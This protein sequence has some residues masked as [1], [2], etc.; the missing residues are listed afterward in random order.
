MRES[1]NII[2]TWEGRTQ[3]GTRKICAEEIKQNLDAKTRNVTGISIPTD[4]R[5][6]V[7]LSG[8]ETGDEICIRERAGNVEAALHAS[9]VEIEKRSESRP[10]AENR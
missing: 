1:E 9:G 4:N 10:L 7:C 5:V 3:S 8:Y 2:I 6:Y